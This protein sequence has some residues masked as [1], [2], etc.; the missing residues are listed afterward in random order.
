MRKPEKRKQQKSMLKRCCEE[1]TVKYAKGKRRD[2][3][4]TEGARGCVKGRGMLK[5]IIEGGG[6]GVIPNQITL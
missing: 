6:K 4:Q 1:P 5:Q 3:A 2:G